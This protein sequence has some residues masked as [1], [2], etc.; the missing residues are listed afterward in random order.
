MEAYKIMETKT[1]STRIEGLL[2][3]FDMQTA[4]FKRAIDEVTDKDMHNRLNTKANHMAWLTG[5]LVQQRYMMTS[6][7]HPGLKQTGEELFKDHKGI[8]DDA[9]YPTNSEYI[10]DWEKITPIAREA[11]VNIP[12]AKLDSEIDM[13]GMKMSY[14]E[15]ISFTI[16]REASIIGQLALW[17][18]LLGYPALKYD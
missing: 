10:K 16:Y 2:T 13:G 9:T 17:R 4:F 7:T 8:Q 12:D 15:L 18:R 11:L 3:L 5:S 6:E 1:A 14:Y